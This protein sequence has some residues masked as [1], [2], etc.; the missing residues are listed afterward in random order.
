[1]V[2]TMSETRKEQVLR[3][4]READGAWVD[5]TELATVEIGGSEGLKRLREL[6]ADGYQITERGN[7]DHVRASWQYRLTRAEAP[8]GTYCT[9]CFAPIERAS[10]PTAL[11]VYVM[12]YCVPCGTKRLFHTRRPRGS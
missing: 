8:T 7:P 11:S 6:R 9:Y 1:M 2:E 10:Y 12:A 3:R 4:L 5:G